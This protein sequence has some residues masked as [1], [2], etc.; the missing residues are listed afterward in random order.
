LRDIRVA[1]GYSGNQLAK[2]LGWPQSKVS[3]LETG[4]QLPTS[5]DV[6]E[7]ALAVGAT[8]SQ[9]DE[10]YVLADGAK[11]EYSTFREMYR[12]Q[13]GAGGQLDYA[14]LEARSSDI[15][16]F[17][18]AMIPGLLQTAEYA[19]E[20]LSAPGGPM[21]HG[22]DE[23]EVLK[24][25]QAR[26]G[27]QQILYQKYR[28]VTVIL[29]E[30]ALRTHLVSRD[31]QRGQIDRLRALVG[32]PSLTLGVVPFEAKVPAYPLSAFHIYDLDLVM[33]ESLTASVTLSDPD[34]VRKYNQAFELL[35]AVAVTGDSLA[36]LFDRAGSR[37]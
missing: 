14:A 3:K 2:Q 12:T 6:N 15:R 5:K 27:R 11:V 33:V 31:A 25:V 35:W 7:W 16:I 34:E 1:A 30:A 4:K 24:M 10:L 37:A 22:A 19:R 13:G 20:L 28:M 32:L 18:P 9:V 36:R 23:A 26:L 21:L 29:L 17:Q 8:P